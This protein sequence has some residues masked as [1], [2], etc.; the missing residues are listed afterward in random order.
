MIKKNKLLII[1]I[2]IIGI[3]LV[4][5]IGVSSLLFCSF[6][7]PYVADWGFLFQMSL[8]CNIPVL[9]SIMYIVMYLLIKKW[10]KKRMKIALTI[11]I[12]ILIMILFFSF[13]LKNI[14]LMGFASPFGSQTT[15]INNY[16]K[17]DSFVEEFSSYDIFPDR[18]PESA[19]NTHYF[20]RYRRIVEQDFDIYL[21]VDLPKAEFEAEKARIEKQYPNAKIIEKNNESVEYQI[22]YEETGNYYYKFV[23]FS[24]KNL[25]VEYVTSYSL[26]GY[27]VGDIPY[28]KELE[29]K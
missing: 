4:L 7:Y 28:F 21:K 19:K 12:T 1:P 13:S 10:L 3:N 16:L 15:N 18:I 27:S 26:E 9:L 6:K 11:I 24:E 2:I 20:Y 29:E 8:Y 25:T 17:L 23:S 22:S 5:F 14:L